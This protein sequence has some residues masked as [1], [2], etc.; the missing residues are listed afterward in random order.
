MAERDTPFGRWAKDLASR[1]HRKV[2]IAAF[3]NKLARIAGRFCGAGRLLPRE[4]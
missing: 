1:V 4:G 3:A 2:A